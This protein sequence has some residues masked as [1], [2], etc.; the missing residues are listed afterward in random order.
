MQY[1]FDQNYYYKEKA[2]QLIKLEAVDIEFHNALL[3]QNVN[4]RIN[5]CFKTNFD[6]NAT[7]YQML[8][9]VPVLRWRLGSISS[10]SNRCDDIWWENIDE[11]KLFV[12]YPNHLLSQL[13]IITGTSYEK[14]QGKKIGDEYRYSIEHLFQIRNQDPITLGIK[15]EGKEERITEIHF[16]PFVSDFSVSYYDR[17]NLIQGLYAQWKYIGSGD[18]HVDIIYS[19]THN[20][21]KQYVINGD[22][23]LL[24]R[25]IEL[26]YSEHEIEIYQLT[27]D[28]FFGEIGRAH[29]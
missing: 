23:H 7:T 15:L 27:E 10:I 4:L 2:A 19:P 16:N 9:N 13:H 5:D 24:D 11:Q 22:E 20:V 29:V 12:K 8:L 28:D 3:P 1:E 21:I 25:N 26:Y 14:I 6:Y 17:K 18:L